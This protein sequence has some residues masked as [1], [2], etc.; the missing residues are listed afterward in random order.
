MTRLFV[1]NASAEVGS[2]CALSSAVRDKAVVTLGARTVQGS[3]QAASAVQGA[4]Q[5][6]EL[7]L[8]IIRGSGAVTGD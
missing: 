4:L 5:H 6:G 7:A 8:F 2:C 3:R 1:I